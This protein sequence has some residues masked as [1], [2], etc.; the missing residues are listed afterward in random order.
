MARI[1]V[2]ALALVLGLGGAAA[3]LAFDGEPALYEAAK[4]EKE[5]TWYTAH[6]DS[7]TAAAVCQGF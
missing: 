1:A 4:K 3:A 5:L 2:L 6:Y 7:E